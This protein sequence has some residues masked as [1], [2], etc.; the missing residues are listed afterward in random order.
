MDHESRALRLRQARV[1]PANI[2]RDIGVSGSTG[3]RERQGWHSLHQRFVGGDTL[4]VVRIELGAPE[5]HG[6]VLDH[7]AEIG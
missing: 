3:T 6:G 1:E 4:V 5:A 7:L 2:Y